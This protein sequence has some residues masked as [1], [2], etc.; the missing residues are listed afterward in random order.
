MSL[1]Q[2]HATVHCLLTSDRLS[3]Q[4][5]ALSVVQTS[6]FEMTLRRKQFISQKEGVI[7]YALVL[8]IGMVVIIDGSDKEIAVPLCNYLGKYCCSFE[9]VSLGEQV[10]DVVYDCVAL[11]GL[12]TK[13]NIGWQPFVASTFTSLDKC[14]ELASFMFGGCFWKACTHQTQQ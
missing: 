10:C 1:A 7:L 6:A 12:A 3:V 13:Q 14:N 9:D 5:A 2:F 4:I 8:M 11:V